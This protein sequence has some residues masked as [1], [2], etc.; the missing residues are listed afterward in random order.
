MMHEKDAV[1]II[2]IENKLAEHGSMIKEALDILK[3][4][5]EFQ[6]YGIAGIKA[7]LDQESKANKL[8]D[9]RK[10]I[11]DK[12]G[13][14]PEFRYPHIKILNCLVDHYDFQAKCFKELQFSQLVR[15]SKIGK[16]KA[17]EYLDLL[18]RKGLIGYRSDGY[19]KY[20]WMT[21]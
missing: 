3:E 2:N 13:N 11:L 7:K 18:I 5:K 14:D 21:A 12:I 1:N 20:Y 19:R 9:I 4:Q 15:L 6:D 10:K 8:Y 17:A 16:N